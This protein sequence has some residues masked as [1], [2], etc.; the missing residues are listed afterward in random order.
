MFHIEEVRYAKRRHLVAYSLFHKR[1]ECWERILD[2]A[3]DVIPE[4]T[5]VPGYRKTSISF[6]NRSYK[7][8][9]RIE[10]KRMP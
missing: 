4:E 6:D 10:R 8:E 7:M 5:E 3:Y 9:Y 2:S 1:S